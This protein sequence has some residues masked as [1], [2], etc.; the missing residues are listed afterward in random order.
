MEIKRNCVWCISNLCRGKPQVDM[1]RIE[2]ALPVLSKILH[3]EID[4]ECLTDACWAISY[5]SEGANERIQ[6][7]IDYFDLRKFIE[8]IYHD[9]KTI[10]KP[11]LRIIG[12]IATGDDVQTQSI[13]NLD[14]LK[15]LKFLLDNPQEVIRKEVCWTISNITAGNV[16][17]IQVKLDF[18]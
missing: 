16:Y 12:N 5:L 4:V 13:L 7:I 8:L 2:P 10:V 6:T 9:S 1:Y 17:Q 11:V 18:F 15:P 14:V 3:N